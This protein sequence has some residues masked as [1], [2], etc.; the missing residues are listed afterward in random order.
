[1][2]NVL[3]KKKES[4]VFLTFTLNYLYKEICNSMNE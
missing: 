3:L 2:R 4:F 1:M